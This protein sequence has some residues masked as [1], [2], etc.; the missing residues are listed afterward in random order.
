MC[1]RVE[2]ASEKMSADL[3]QMYEAVKDSETNAKYVISVFV[4]SLSSEVLTI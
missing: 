1:L 3:F 2:S 4:D